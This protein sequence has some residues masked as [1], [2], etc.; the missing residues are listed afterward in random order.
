MLRIWKNG[1]GLGEGNALPS[2]LPLIYFK[3]KSAM[4]LH[5]TFA[6]TLRFFLLCLFQQFPFSIKH[7]VFFFV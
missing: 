5:F 6:I 3:L 2:P 7:H 1:H 4:V